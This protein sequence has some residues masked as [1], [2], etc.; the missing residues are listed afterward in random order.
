M[1]RVTPL[2]ILSSRRQKRYTPQL[3]GRSCHS[4]SKAGGYMTLPAVGGC[5]TTRNRFGYVPPGVA[6]SPRFRD[7]HEKFPPRSPTCS[8][9]PPAAGL[10]HLLCAVRRR[11]LGLQLLFDLPRPHPSSIQA[12][13]P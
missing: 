10:V 2:P 7:D 1:G 11:F 6:A 12:K 9:L 13:S 5:A 4:P 8:A 3:V